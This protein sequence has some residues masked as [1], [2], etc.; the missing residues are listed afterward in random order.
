MQISFQQSD[1]TFSAPITIPVGVA[2]S[3][4]SFADV[5]GDGLLDIVVTNQA[6]GTVTVLL[7][8]KTHSFTTVETFRSSLDTQGA[9]GAMATSLAQPVSVAVGNFTGDGLTDLV[10]V[11]RG[12]HS[13]T[14]LPND[15]EGGFSEPSAALTTSTS[16]GLNINDQ[17]GPVVSGYFNG[18]KQPL[19]LAILM[20]DTAQVWIFTGDG[21]GHF[22]HTDTIGVGASPTGLTVV[23]GSGP[24][25]SNLLVGNSFGD[26]LQL[27]GQGN[28]TFQPLTGQ[29]TP[30]S[31]TSLN[32]DNSP[33]VLV[34][35]Q[36]HNN[37]SIQ[38][39]TAPGSAQFV[40]QQMVHIPNS[41]ENLAPG[42]VD[43]AK[44]EG[45]NNPD[46]AIV[47]GSGSNQVLVYHTIDVN[48]V[49]GVPTLTVP[50]TY[51][52]GDDP[53]DVTLANLTGNPNGV[54]DMIIA[55]EGSNDVSILFGS[56]VNGQWVGTQGPRLQ[57]GG[58]GPIAT[59][60]QQLPG[61]PYPDLFIFNSDGTVSVL[62]GVGQGFFD[63]QATDIR[64]MTIPGGSLG[65]PSFFNN[66]A[67]GFA[68]TA[69]GSIVEINLA[70]LTASVVFQA[71]AGE[72]VNALES[73]A[74][75]AVVA[76]FSNGSVAA[77]LPAV[78][79][80]LFV[81][82]DLSALTAG[83]T[84]PSDLQ[85]FDN[86]VFATNAGSDQVF[87]FS[88]DFSAGPSI[89]VT[90]SAENLTLI[91]TVLFNGEPSTST[92]SETLGGVN[93]EAGEGGNGAATTLAANVGIGGADPVLDEG[94]FS[95]AANQTDVGIDVYEKLRDIE[96]DPQEPVPDTIGTSTRL[97]ELHVADATA[98][99]AQRPEG[100]NELFSS[101]STE[102]TVPL[103]PAA[104]ETAIAVVQ[105]PRS[106]ESAQ[107]PPAGRT[108][109]DND[110]INPQ[111][112]SENSREAVVF[113]VAEPTA[114][115]SSIADG[116]DSEQVTVRTPVVSECNL[117]RCLLTSL[118]F[119][120]I[121]TRSEDAERRTGLRRTFSAALSY[122]R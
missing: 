11:N 24:G 53:V 85:V 5:N 28:G 102:L 121:F 120:G 93:A 108:I 57:S 44:L 3:D 32:G 97:E 107:R 20:L 104:S 100:L 111:R 103:N 34:G 87:V 88:L 115:S 75:G 90:P 112:G 78:S 35:D 76:A 49:T 68:P 72:D 113:A 26:I 7:N 67:V 69:S 14:V 40:T 22:T 29:S 65:V 2:P 18:P 52:V 86:Q 33:D 94:S 6:S 117:E 39:P 116:N 38:V 4:I 98:S 95:L 101:W 37:V 9:T 74:D 118:V 54:P 63:D 36:L 84:N 62:R 122:D 12:A 83:L 58:V 80:Q 43:W 13:F 110:A 71:P 109:P 41:I 8:D 48:P 119:V 15:G 56:I 45:Q 79:G 59:A 50:T 10:V 23:P 21:H 61:N 89:E 82:G 47:M 106:A 55:N 25:L 17:P 105:P 16:D 73:L 19:D 99:L 27:V 1:G 42:V 91:A 30:L 31:V 96:L 81:G 64:T 46:D 70:T 66:G 92:S 114:W 60:V 51:T 77:L